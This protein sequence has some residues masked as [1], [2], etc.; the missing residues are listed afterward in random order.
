MPIP[1]V[2]GKR[3]EIRR[4]LA[5]RS[6]ELLQ[7]YRDGSGATEGCPLRRAMADFGNEPV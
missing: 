7:N 1:R 5:R 4:L 2:K 3:R 6:K